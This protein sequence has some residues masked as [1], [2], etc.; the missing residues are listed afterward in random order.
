MEQYKKLIQRILNDGSQRQDRTGI[1]TKSI[2]GH[3]LTFN[4]T[5]SF[6][7]LSLKQ[8]MWRS[9]FYEMIWF[10]RGDTNV[11]YL[12]DRGIKIWNEWSDKTGS[13]GPGYG[14]S[15]RKWLY[16]DED[17]YGLQNLSRLEIDQVKDLIK[18][19]QK[20][21][22]SRRHIMTTW[23]PGRTQYMNLPPCHGLVL[24]GY[25]TEAQEFDLH[26]YQRSCDT[27]LGLPFNIAEWAFFM[28]LIGKLCKLTPR[29]L[30]ISLGDAHIYLNHLD[31]VNKMLER[32]PIDQKIDLVIKKEILSI[33][34]IESLEIDTDVEIQNYKYHPFIKFKVAV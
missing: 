15:L 1:G 22:F 2:F 24:Q 27:V 8:T 21:P 13:I 23:H 7:L 3:Q 16:Y 18:G 32:E 28:H 30:I 29:N 10:L 17:D 26:M 34:D 9:A 12:N 5:E 14:A 33:Q 11:K 4:L 6:P 31:G 19:I 25:V 20:N